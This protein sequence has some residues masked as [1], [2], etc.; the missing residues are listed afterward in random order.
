MAGPAAD[1]NHRLLMRYAEVVDM[2]MLHSL[3][4]HRKL[5]G[6]FVTAASDSYLRSSA[7]IMIV[8]RE[9]A[10]WGNGLSADL[11]CPERSASAHAY[12]THQMQHHR[13]KVREVGARSKF[14]QFYRETSRKVAAPADR[15]S[16]NAPIWANLFC[17]DAERTRP[18]RRNEASAIEIIRL[19]GELLRIQIEV[20]Q[21]QLIVFV[22]GSSC[23][24]HLKEH[25]KDL[26]D[27]RVHI[28]KTIWEFKLPRPQGSGEAAHT[29]AFRTPHPRHS[30]TDRARSAVV[31]EALVPGSVARH[32]ASLQKAAGSAS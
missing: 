7:R 13:R 6:L 31:A 1:L 26:C 25:F 5:S 4:A 23:D 14:F 10:G 9:T 18:D 2:N 28:P 21:P 24:R 32:A 12:L 22:T 30:A 15:S 29:I 11:A 8:G 19:S 17:F 3:A 27:S 20:L 16:G